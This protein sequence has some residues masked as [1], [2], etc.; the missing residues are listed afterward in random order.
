V[1]IGAVKAR[2]PKTQPPKRF[3]VPSDINAFSVLSLL[4]SIQENNGISPSQAA[5]LQ[6]TITKIERDYFS[7]L[8]VANGKAL[9]SD[10]LQ[11]VAQEWVQLADRS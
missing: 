6:Q 4:K 10:R 7:S 1:A 5:D 11:H 8:H 2:K 3:T 9:N